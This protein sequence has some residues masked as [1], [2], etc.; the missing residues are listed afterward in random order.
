MK[1]PLTAIVFSIEA[2][3]CYENIIPVVITAFVAFLVTEMFGV[4]SINDTV[5][6][7]REDFEEKGKKRYEADGFVVVRQGSFAVGKQVRDIFWPRNLFVLSIQ[8][9][10][11]HEE[12]DEHGG[13]EIKEGDTLHI[14]YSTCDEGATLAE[15][16][17]IVGEQEDLLNHATKD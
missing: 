14:R 5:I 4:K 1:M 12:V 2:L 9:P 15:L 6:E 17:A 7:L 11:S 3:S 8:H 10:A 13:R 16:F